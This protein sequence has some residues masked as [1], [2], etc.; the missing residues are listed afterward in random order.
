VDFFGYQI[1]P[2]II[3]SSAVG[4]FLTVSGFVIGMRVAKERADRAPLR[5]LYQDLYAHFREIKDAAERGRPREW[6][7]YKLKGDQHMP[8]VRSMEHDGSLNLLPQRLS[9]QFLDAEKR[10]LKS[11]H[12]FRKVVR[13]ELTPLVKSIVERHVTKA[14]EV[15]SGRPYRSFSI[16]MMALKMKLDADLSQQ[17]SNANVGVG[18][19]MAMDRGHSHQLYVY[20]EKLKSGR[21]SMFFT[22]SSM[23]YRPTL[24]L[25]RP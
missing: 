4:I 7:D 9:R 14:S 22:R 20:P 3:L 23:R 5:Q 25:N 19:E 2:A 21:L 18:I 6:G 16:G 15:I 12:D 11:S 1:A 8:L 10:A 17:L 13:E 24:Q